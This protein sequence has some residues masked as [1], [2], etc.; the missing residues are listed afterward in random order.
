MFI[1]IGYWGTR[2]RKIKASYYFFLYTCIGF[3]FFIIWYFIMLYDLVGTFE[4]EV[5]LNFSFSPQEQI[6]LFFFFFIPFAIKIPMFPFHLW[7]PE[8][9][10]EAPTIGS[11]ILAALLLKLGGYGFLRF[12]ITMFPYGCYYFQSLIFALGAAGVF[13]ASLCSFSSKWLKTYYC[14]FFHCPYEFNCFRNFFIYAWRSWRSVLFNDCVTELFLR[15]YFF[16]LVNFIW[17]LSY[18]GFQTLQWLGSSDA[19]IFVFFY[20]FYVR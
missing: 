7:L 13:F 14:L 20:A 11:V 12:T 5:L 8:A 15:D 18:A 9:H 1:I 10:V 19:F 6:Y 2:E 16:A 17:S 4:Y 3:I